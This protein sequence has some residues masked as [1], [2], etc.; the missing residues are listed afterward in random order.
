M[1]FLL[2]RDFRE[3]TLCCVVQYM[4]ICLHFYIFSEWCSAS[5]V[6]SPNLA[7]LIQ[8]LWLVGFVK[9]MFAFEASFY[10][11]WIHTDSRHLLYFEEKQFVFNVLCIYGNQLKFSPFGQFSPAFWERRKQKARGHK[12][13]YNRSR[14]YCVCWTTVTSNTSMSSLKTDNRPRSNHWNRA[15]IAPQCL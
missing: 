9:F 6:L 13:R 1:C 4:I 2:S 5:S 8:Y 15:I 11:C 14:G 7:D 3:T 10:F 12:V